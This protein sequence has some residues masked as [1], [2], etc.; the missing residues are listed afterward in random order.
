M[1]VQGNM[2][3]SSQGLLANFGLMEAA[4]LNAKGKTVINES[5]VE[6]RSISGGYQDELKN[7]AT[8]RAT[9]GNLNVEA[10]ELFQARG[11]KFEAKLNLD[12]KSAGKLYLGAQQLCSEVTTIGKHSYYHRYTLN[13][14]KSQVNAGQNVNIWSGE[15]MIFEGV[16]VAAAGYIHAKS[17]STLENRTV[18][19]IYQEESRTESKGGLLKGKKTESTQTTIDTVVKNAF[20]AGGDVNFESEGDNIQ[21]APHIESGGSTTIRSNQGKVIIKADKSSYMTSTQKSSKSAVWQS[22]QQKGRYDETIEMLEILAKGGIHI[23]GAKGVET[24]IKG[25]KTQTR[26]LD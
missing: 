5:L 16:D 18:H 20:K 13:N 2:S 10:T 12:L 22:Q 7:Q 4:N 3:L 14:H 11:A 9:T 26:S 15:G 21:Q 6:R 23:W 25:G 1:V 19:N 8:M 17:E 24:E